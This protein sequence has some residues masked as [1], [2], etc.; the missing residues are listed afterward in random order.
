MATMV[1]RTCWCGKA[2]EARATDVRRGWGKSCC[3]KH[4]ARARE[5]KARATE[6][7]YVK[8]AR[9]LDEGMSGMDHDW[10]PFG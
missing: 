6:P 5:A 9:T 3:K 4:A 1:Q 8:Q 7:V 10:S 2:F